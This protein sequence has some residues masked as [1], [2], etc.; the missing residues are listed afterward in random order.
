MTASFLL[1]ILLLQTPAPRPAGTVISG[2]T[3]A[4]TARYGYYSL[5]DGVIRYSTLD[6]LAPSRQTGNPVQ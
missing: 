2:R 4:G 6:M 3:S 5:P 1:A